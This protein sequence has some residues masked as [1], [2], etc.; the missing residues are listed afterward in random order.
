[1]IVNVRFA[2]DGVLVCLQADAA[3]EVVVRRNDDGSRFVHGD[4]VDRKQEPGAPGLKAFAAL[5]VSSGAQRNDATLAA[6][7]AICQAISAPAGAY[8]QCIDLLPE[9]GQR[10]SAP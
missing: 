3:W 9:N 5:F 8:E 4:W 6:I 1:M 7:R 10:M 2:S